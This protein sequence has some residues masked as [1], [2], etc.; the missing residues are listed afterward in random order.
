VA[1]PPEEPPFWGGVVTRLLAVFVAGLAA[2]L[3]FRVVVEPIL[4]GDA[5]R[6]QRDH[7]PAELRNR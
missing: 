7:A 3:L 4:R 1:R 5:E 2:L 6:V